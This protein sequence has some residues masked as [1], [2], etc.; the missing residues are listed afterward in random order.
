MK[1]NVSVDKILLFILKA[2][3]S[4]FFHLNVTFGLYRNVWRPPSAPPVT[5]CFGFIHIICIILWKDPLEN[6]MIHLKELAII[7][8]SKSK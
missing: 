1:V 8:K 7:N 3:I 6:E 5:Q 4:I 2:I